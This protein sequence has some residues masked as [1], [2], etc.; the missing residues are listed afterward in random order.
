MRVIDA[1][2]FGIRRL[3]YDVVRYC[4]VE[5]NPFDLLG[6]LI[7][8]QL[9]HVRLDDRQ[10]QAP[11]RLADTPGQP[12][13]VDD[14]RRGPDAPDESDVHDAMVAPSGAGGPAL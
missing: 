9:V 5:V 13:V 14:R 1:I 2:Q 10:I 12:V 3:G 7:R 4:P 8:D 6:L 11:A